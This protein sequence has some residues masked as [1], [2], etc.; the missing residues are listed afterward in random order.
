MSREKK[1]RSVEEKRIRKYLLIF[2]IYTVVMAGIVA[3]AILLPKKSSLPS[4][5]DVTMNFSST[6]LM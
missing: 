1:Q 5:D 3:A 2:V 4:R 6:Y